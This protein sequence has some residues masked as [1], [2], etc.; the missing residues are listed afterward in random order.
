MDSLPLLWYKGVMFARRSRKYLVSALAATMACSLVMPPTTFAAASVSASAGGWTCTITAAPPVNP[1]TGALRNQL[2]GSASVTCNG[3]A[4]SANLLITVSVVV[5]ELDPTAGFT[6]ATCPLAASNF[7]LCEDASMRF[8]VKS[9]AFTL[10]KGKTTAVTALA[11]T[12]ACV[13]SAEPGSTSPLQEYATRAQIASGL[14]TGW[15]RTVPVD[16]SFTCP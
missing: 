4:A 15:V 14:G 11:G 5:V 10:I 8:S 7:T 13:K 16:N 9:T 1:L 12:N 2:S 6:L 3:A